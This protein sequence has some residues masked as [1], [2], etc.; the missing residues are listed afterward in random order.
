MNLRLIIFATLLM[1]L[2]PT[3]NTITAE[4]QNEHLPLNMRE[5]PIISTRP[6]VPISMRTYVSRENARRAQLS[7]EAAGG[8]VVGGIAGCFILVCIAIGLCRH[9]FGWK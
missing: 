2:V 1:A 6:R 8:L 9:I 5:F 7:S 3:S 4:S